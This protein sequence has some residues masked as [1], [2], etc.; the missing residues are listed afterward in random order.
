MKNDFRY[1]VDYDYDTEHSCAD[2]GCDCEG[3]CRCGRIYN[4]R[5][6]E[7]RIS[8]ITEDIYK[9]LEGDDKKAKRRSQRISEIFGVR[10]E[11]VDRYCIHRILT[12]HKVWDPENWTVGVEGG[13][14]GEEIGEVELALSVMSKV[15]T[16]CADM[17]RLGTASDKIRFVL[18]LEY[19][20]L[21]RGLAKAEFELASI[22]LKDLDFKKMSQ[23]HIDTVTSENLQHYYQYDL[24]RGIIRGDKIIDGFHR[25]LAVDNNRNFS[26]FKVK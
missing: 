21:L 14:Y 23:M 4:P 26:V 7:V 13:Y 25:I 19:G 15:E 5:V 22:S 18:R 24:P 17:Y 12:F 9:F 20:K 10:D 2:S 1:G 8:S 11:I 3:I 6:T 16:D